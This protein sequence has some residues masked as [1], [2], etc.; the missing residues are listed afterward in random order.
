MTTST[1]A[2]SFSTT[3]APVELDSLDTRELYAA[4]DSWV[5]QCSV[6]GRGNTPE[7]AQFRAVANPEIR[8]LKHELR[9]RKLPTDSVLYYARVAL[10]DAQDVR[11]TQQ[12]ALD[13]AAQ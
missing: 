3:Q 12:C 7:A 13:V 8:T 5:S 1:L 11:E 4:L 9:R 6:H 10:A 2:P